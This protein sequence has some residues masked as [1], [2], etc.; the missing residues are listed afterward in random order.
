MKNIFTALAFAALAT[1]DFGVL[2]LSAGTNAYAYTAR[3][4]ARA[5]AAR[6]STA[7]RPRSGRVGLHSYGVRR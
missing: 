2:S 1:A 4:A 3:P 7:H 5:P 6:H